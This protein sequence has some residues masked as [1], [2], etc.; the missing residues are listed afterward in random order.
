MRSKSSGMPAAICDGARR[1][2]A[3][4]ALEHHRLGHARE[5]RRA[6]RHLVEDDAEREQIAAAVD[7]EAPRLLRRHVVDGAQRRTGGRELIGGPRLGRDRPASGLGQLRHAEVQ[8]LHFTAPGDEQVRRLE[9]AVD[10]ALAMRGVERVGDVLAVAQHLVQRDRAARDPRLQR[11]ALQQLHHHELLAGVLADVVQRADVRMIERR[12][13][14]RLAEEALHRLRLATRFL[15]QELDRD[16]AAQ[17]QVLGG[18]DHAHAAAAERLL[19]SI[20]RD[21]LSGHA[22]SVSRS[23]STSRI[24]RA[25][26]TGVNGFCRNDLPSSS[27]PVR[28]M[29]SSV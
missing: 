28:T 1:G 19:D 18:V 20:V 22:A 11:L 27:T 24:L 7:L 25:S 10:D 14:A 23:S 29:A 15:G 3:E 12:D 2:A 17:P 5:R 9:V 4:D 13:G 6:G 21:L 16:L 26:C 8:H